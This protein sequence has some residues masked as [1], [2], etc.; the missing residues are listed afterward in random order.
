[1]GEAQGVGEGV[2]L[3]EVWGPGVGE[4]GRGHEAP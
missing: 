3:R 4:E 1:M 2:A